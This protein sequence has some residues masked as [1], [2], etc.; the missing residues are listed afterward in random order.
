M[1]I[2]CF[3]ILKL[4]SY[5]Y[6]W[7]QTG[8][9]WTNGN[10]AWLFSFWTSRCVCTHHHLTCSPENSPNSQ[11]R[12]MVDEL[13]SLSWIDTLPKWQHI[14]AVAQEQNWDW[15][16]TQTLPLLHRESKLHKPFSWCSSVPKL[17]WLR[18][19][20]SCDA[21]A[22]PRLHPP[23]AD[24]CDQ[25]EWQLSVN[26]SPLCMDWDLSSPHRG[27]RG[28]LMHLYSQGYSW[29]SPLRLNR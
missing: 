22:E 5:Q 26:C 4:A 29:L 6:L 15:F 25:G 19:F 27:V 11:L 7:Q 13:I 1:E 12:F 21:G 18:Y 16:E 9:V 23:P 20:S 17:H 28:H 24:Q 3:L 10:I 8:R 14:A 2:S